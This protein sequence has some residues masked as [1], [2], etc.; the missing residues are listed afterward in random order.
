MSTFAGGSLSSYSTHEI[1][2]EIYSRRAALEKESFTSPATVAAHLAHYQEKKKEYFILITLDN[3]NHLIK[4]RTIAVG[5]VDQCTAY[6]RNIFHAAL[7][8]MASGIIIA[9]NHPGGDPKPSGQDITL[10]KQIEKI[11]KGLD[12]RLLDHI[13]VSRCGHFSFSENSLL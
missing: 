5:S 1:L 12:I 8:D 13:I 3:K 7:Q 9:H 10:T 2:S 11:A 4:R 6:P